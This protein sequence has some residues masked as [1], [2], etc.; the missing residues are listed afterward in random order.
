[1]SVSGE[2]KLLA[3]DESSLAI[4]PE[5]HTELRVYISLFKR[6]TVAVTAGNIHARFHN[7]DGKRLCKWAISLNETRA[8]EI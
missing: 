6:N 3:D 5:I 8:W 1:M 4:S 2:C 7:H